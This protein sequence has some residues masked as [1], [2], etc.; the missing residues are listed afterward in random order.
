[1]AFTKVRPSMMDSVYV[2]NDC[3][4][5]VFDP[6][7]REDDVFHVKWSTQLGKHECPVERE[8]EWMSW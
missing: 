2:C 3:G 5:L 1:V 6:N 8:E 7:Y 4:V